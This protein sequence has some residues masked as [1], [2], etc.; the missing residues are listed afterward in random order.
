MAVLLGGIYAVVW[1]FWRPTRFELEG[2]ALKI[3]WPL[4]S[5]RL[6]LRIVDEIEVMD[7]KTFRSRVRWA[8]RVGA[9][10]LWGGFGWLATGAGWVR[11]YVSRSDGLVLLTLAGQAP[12]LISPED[13]EGFAAAVRGPSPHRP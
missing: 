4:R 2:D 10:G 9:G 3:V 11:F 6:P 7:A 5:W 1:L 8:V 12:L 13:P